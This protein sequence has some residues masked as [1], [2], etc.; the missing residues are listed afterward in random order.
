MH[1]PRPVGPLRARLADPRG[2]EP[3]LNP[4]EGYDPDA[5]HFVPLPRK[6]PQYS[7]SSDPRTGV[8]EVVT[9]E[10]GGSQKAT[11]TTW[12]AGTPERKATV[13]T[14]EHPGRKAPTEEFKALIDDLR[15]RNDPGPILARKRVGPVGG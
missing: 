4:F 9:S 1:R 3:L 10:S 2:K 8:V 14:F 5:K 11:W 12:G 6:Y 15:K 7:I 13:E